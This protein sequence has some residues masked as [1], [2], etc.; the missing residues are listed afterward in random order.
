MTSFKK[1]DFS[2]FYI[3]NDIMDIPSLLIFIVGIVLLPVIFVKLITVDS[4][5]K[6]SHL[7]MIM[8]GFFVLIGFVAAFFIF[9]SAMSLAMIA[10]SSLLILPFLIKI[11]EKEA[12]ATEKMKATHKNELYNWFNPS[13]ISKIFERHESLIK[14]YIFL[15]FGMALEYA[16][17]FAVLQPAVGESAFSHQLGLFGPTGEFFSSDILSQILENNLQIAIISFALSIFYGAGSIF[18]LNYNASIVGVM[19]GSTFRTLLWGTPLFYSNI[20]FYIPHTFLEIIAYLLA[21]VAGGLLIK[22]LRRDILRDSAVLFSLSIILIFI[23]GYVE[24]AMLA[25]LA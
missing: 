12:P 24:V 16:M 18:I 21:A 19:Y 8:A 2:R 9:S 6:K 20:L 17:L 5:R 22:G 3:R 7:A 4:L 14:F 10:F 1:N 13:S 15:F 23:A 25:N 11:L